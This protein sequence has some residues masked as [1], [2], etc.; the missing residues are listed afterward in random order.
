MKWID[1]IVETLLELINE[2][3]LDVT[4]VSKQAGYASNYITKLVNGT[5]KS[6]SND[7]LEPIV[8]ILGISLLDFL[9]IAEAKKNII[10]GELKAKDAE[11][12]KGIFLRNGEFGEV[13]FKEKYHFLKQKIITAFP[14]LQV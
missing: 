8:N 7:E 5:K 9:Q 3:E 2:K 4:K 12:L 6:I 14:E 1:A 11:E 13:Q 10:R